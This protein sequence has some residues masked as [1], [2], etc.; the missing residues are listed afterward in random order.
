MKTK[1]DG[2]HGLKEATQTWHHP[3]ACKQTGQ[4]NI[5][6][7]LECSEEKCPVIAGGD[8]NDLLELLITSVA[9]YA[10]SDLVHL[11]W[12]LASETIE[13]REDSGRSKS[14]PQA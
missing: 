3:R 14:P 9:R 13:R 1:A 6:I 2:D 8:L 11:K 12:S 4:E 7:A 10:I 5:I